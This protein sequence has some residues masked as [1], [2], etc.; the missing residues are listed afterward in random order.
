[1]QRKAAT[2]TRELKKNPHDVTKLVKEDRYRSIVQQALVFYIAEL[3]RMQDIIVGEE[4]IA[5]IKH[6]SSPYESELNVAETM[7][8]SIE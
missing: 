5:H 4:L 1:M 3:R 6:I 7:K 2:V 8:Q